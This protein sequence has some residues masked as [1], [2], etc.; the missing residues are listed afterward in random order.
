MDHLVNKLGY[1]DYR[2]ALA[3]NKYIL[4]A[5]RSGD[6]HQI[7]RARI[8]Q[9]GLARLRATR[10]E[11]LER[12][13]HKQAS[14]AATPGSEAYNNIADDYK[15]NELMNQSGDVAELYRDTVTKVRLEKE[16]EFDNISRIHDRFDYLKDPDNFVNKYRSQHDLKSTRYD[17]DDD[18][19][20][21]SEFSDAE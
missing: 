5:K 16:Y 10:R 14:A 7:A 19:Q 4:E 3:C 21:A 18:I 2:D 1:M 12:E 20:T 13:A 9:A 15:L 11:G 6:Y 17:S 8:L